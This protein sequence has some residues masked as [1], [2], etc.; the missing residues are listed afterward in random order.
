MTKAFIHPTALVET[1][2]VGEG[3]RIWA[4]AHLL[5]GAVV[6]QHCNIGDQVYI[7]SG[8]VVGSFVTLKNHVALWEGITIEDG[9][10]VG[11]SVIFTNDRYPR[12]PRLWA[13]APRYASK[14]DWLLPTHVQEGCSIGAGAIILPG[15]RLGPYSMIAF[16]MLPSCGSTRWNGTPANDFGDQS[17]KTNRSFGE[18]P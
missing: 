12:S 17:R 3:T 5:P 7:E 11:P 6:G 18:R 2:H 15:L 4:Y 16:A 1:E 9:V 10:F 8:A 13:A 14:D